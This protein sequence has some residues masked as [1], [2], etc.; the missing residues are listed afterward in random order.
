MLPVI[1]YTLPA[2]AAECLK[3]PGVEAVDFV[4]SQ[5]TDVKSLTALSNQHPY[6]VV[7]IHLGS[8]GLHDDVEQWCEA[9]SAIR[10]LVSTGWG[11]TISVSLSAQSPETGDQAALNRV[12][13]VVRA[14]QRRFEGARLYL[15]LLPAVKE[16]STPQRDADFLA[17]VLQRTHCGW[18]LNL[19]DVY[20]RSRNLG[21][22]AYDQI[23]EVLP[24]AASV[25]IRVSSVRFEKRI[26]AVVTA[27]E[28]A[29][30][31][32]IWS[33][34]RHS[35]VL[36]SHKTRAVVIAGRE[37][38]GGETPRRSDLRHARFI[39]DRVQGRQRMLKQHPGVHD[40][41]ARGSIRRA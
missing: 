23:A 24:A 41:L 29:I 25:L 40:Y 16:P 7:N 33:L 1:G 3:D 17:E 39:V 8:L 11:T 12:P 21:F 31:D 14:L 19:G 28:G 15:E 6:G 37:L 22:D 27:T 13:D 10:E 2:H 35:L 38:R 26:G 9:R 5:P 32:E 20:A 34:L 18:L 30:P 36:G 4:L